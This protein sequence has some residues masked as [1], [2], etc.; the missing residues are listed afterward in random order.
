M[1]SEEKF[2][3]STYERLL[4]N[5]CRAGDCVIMSTSFIDNESNYKLDKSIVKK[6]LNYMQN[7]HPFL[8]AYLETSRLTNKM[9]LKVPLKEDSHGKIKL[10]WLD[11]TEN[12]VTREQLINESANFHSAPF[13]NDSQSLLWKIQVI[14]YKCDEKLNF[15]MN[16]VTNMAISDGISITCLSIEIINII[17]SLIDGKECEE[18]KVK[19]KPVADL[20]TL[21]EERNLFN[22]SHL[23]MIKKLNEI[24]K[25]QL[26]LPEKFKTKKRGFLLDLFRLDKIMTEKI[27]SISKSKGIRLTSYFQTITIYALRKLFLENDEPFPEQVPIEM[28]AN[29]RFRLNPKV[30][31]NACRFLTAILAFGTE[32]FGKYDDFWADA[33]HVHELIIENTKTETGALFSITHFKYLDFFNQI[34]RFTPSS[35]TACKFMSLLDIDVCDLGYSNLGSFINDSKKELE[36]KL[37]IKEIYC[38]DL[39]LSVPK[40]TSSIIMHTIY[41]KGETMFQIGANNYYIDSS[42]LKRFKELILETIEETI[43]N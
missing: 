31:L 21:C 38:S 40:I 41:W 34:F 37:S 25:N 10:D 29:L 35:E 4:V 16:L 6:A 15:V 27:I 36:G 18:M 19:L 24:R 8:N 23:K 9:V 12:Q 26:S 11:L 5:T 17:N 22:Q 30:D 14:E 7:R 39:L 20:H 1:N 28:P 43:K 33:K 13:S 42:F 2:P 3:L 32:S